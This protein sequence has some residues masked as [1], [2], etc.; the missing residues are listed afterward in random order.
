MELIHSIS[1]E[2]FFLVPRPVHESYL[3]EEGEEGIEI[4]SKV[5][6]VV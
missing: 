6:G 1:Q 3:Y 2:I 4:E 5:V